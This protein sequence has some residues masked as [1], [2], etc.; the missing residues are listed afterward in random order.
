MS[1][2]ERGPLAFMAR[3]HVAA[4]LLMV[5]FIV[6]GLMLAPN[7]KQEVFPEVDLDTVA[8]QVTYP[9]AGPEEVEQGVI[10]AVEEAVRGLDGVR[11]VRSTASESVGRVTVELSGD[12]DPGETLNDIKSAVDRITSFPGDAERPVV[13]LLTNR[14]QV[15][16][17]VVYGDKSEKELRALGDEIRDEILQEKNVSLAELAGVRAPEISIE[18]PQS[19]LREYGLTLDQV[20]QAVRSASVELPGGGVKT[21]AGEVLMRTTERRDFGDEFE[22]IAV[23][24]APDGTSIRVRDLAVVVD[25]FAEVDR[26]AFF[27][28]KRAVRVEVFRVGDQTPIQVADAV[29]SYVEN[30]M[31]RLPEGVGIAVWSDRSE[32]FRDRMDLLLRN[33]YLGVFLVLLT[34]GLF[35]EIRLAMWVTSGIAVSVLGAMLFMPMLDVSINMVSLFAFI[36][37]LGIVV[38]DAIVAGEAIY[39]HRQQGKPIME[40]SIEG[41]REVAMPVVF[42]VLTTVV[43]FMPLLYIP[44]MMGKFWNNI[45]LIVIP[46]LLISLIDALFILPAHLG[47]TSRKSSGI[48]G[49]IDE[50][51]EAFSRLLER[52]IEGFYRPT[53]EFAFRYRYITLAAALGTLVLAFG[54]I[55]GGRL[56]FTFFPKVEGDVITASL[57]M[58][59]GSPVN[60]TREVV[61]RIT[62][63][64]QETLKELGG[65]ASLSRGIYA[66]IGGGATGGAG[67]H[68]A[69]V[70]VFLVPTKDREVTTT[71]FTNA[72]R[73]KVGE[74]PGVDTLQFQFNI[75]PARGQPVSVELSH[76]DPQ[77][78]EA[79]AARTAEAMATFAGVF[80]VDAGFSRGKE[81]L[82]LKLK[83]EARALGLTETDLARQVRSAFYGAEVTR[84]QRGRDEVRVFVRRPLTERS[85]EFDV[86]QMIVRTPAG[87][88]IPLGE[89]AE[90]SRGKSFTN[91]QRVDG[92][93]VLTATADVDEA[94]TSGQIVT[95]SVLDDV[96]PA[97]AADIP[98]LSYGAA[99]QEQDRAEMMQALRR[100]FIFA[101]L[102][103]FALMAFALGS[104]TQP[105]MI[106]M[107]I[108][109]GVVGAILGHLVL[110][111]DISIIS[112][113]GMVALAGVVVNDSIV[114]T[115]AINTFR[116]EGMTVW[117]AVV[118]GGTRRFRPVLLTSLTTFFGLAP[119]ILETSPQAKFLVPMAISLGFGI[120][121]TTVIVLGVV[122]C[123]YLVA[124]DFKQ[125]FI[126]VWGKE[127]VEEE[128]TELA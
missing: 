46:I 124:D 85:S 3:N 25:G 65:D 4:N 103:M 114:L 111:Y 55:A 119:M 89:A 67:S 62:I 27:N 99:G 29:K 40:A 30:K 128:V 97:I 52:F 34:L 95:Q 44:G 112:M 102:A 23:R 91:I 7:I 2:L 105:I 61:E 53:A 36:L 8:I 70:Q 117:D 64:A 54:M 41:I 22:D 109:F 75:G 80:D 104:Y 73:K 50:K 68:L 81:Q 11:E 98:G 21:N 6:G 51:Q 113:M 76:R 38:D 48:I 42:S 12:V 90:V 47:H 39:H 32:I 96:M 79:A 123:F 43:A 16:S 1:V 125:L 83:P 77:I 106:M 82:D 107:A 87:G 88:E 45:P 37:T 66:D 24:A 26:E 56:R 10:L 121:F 35:L 58:P 108:P 86:E 127:P 28:G 100:N 115:D 59:F 14:N 126:K 60:N 78:L 84:Q 94:V 122:P 69:N 15:I 18:V 72:W 116:K 63:G 74:V 101:L 110:G 71:E 19:K 49:W 31:E 118:A 93:R 5:I 92:R 57:Q 20:A 33:A 17:L 13:S 120:M 9:G